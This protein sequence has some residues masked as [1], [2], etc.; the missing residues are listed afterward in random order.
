MGPATVGLAAVQVNIFV[1]TI[2]ASHEPGAVSWLNYAFR[3]LYLPI[4]LF[5]VALGTIATS[6]PGA[7]RGR[8]RHGGPARDAPRRA[9]RCSRS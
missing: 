9:L 7:A 1:S 4:G 5:G 8:R 6:G 3:I 2:F